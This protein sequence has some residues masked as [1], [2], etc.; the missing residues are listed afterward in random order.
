[1]RGKMTCGEM[2]RFHVAPLC[3]D[4]NTVLAEAARDHLRRCPSCRAEWE[5]Y[6]P[7]DL[8]GEGRLPLARVSR[9][10]T[11]RVL[12][13]IGPRASAVQR[14]AD[15]PRH[16]RSRAPRFMLWHYASA[17]LATLVLVSIDFFGAFGGLSAPARRLTAGLGAACRV[18]QRLVET[19]TDPAALWR[20][21]RS[22]A[23]GFGERRH[24]QGGMH[25]EKE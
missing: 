4:P 2:R 18:T 14:P 8:Y 17:A 11:A 10:F 6:F 21:W 1:M 12:A 9:D 7:L 5:D 20:G 23:R 15:N 19:G 24:D 22:A 25:D 3:A 16:V 13:A